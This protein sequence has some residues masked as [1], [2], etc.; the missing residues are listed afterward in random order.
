M[1]RAAY[2]VCLIVLELALVSEVVPPLA[3]ALRWRAAIAQAG[4]G[5]EAALRLTIALLGAAG[6][7][8]ALAAP[9]LA[10]LRHRQR[11]ALRFLGLPRWAVATVI[12]GAAAFAACSLAAPW[13]ADLD[14]RW[15]EAVVEVEQS[16]VLAATALMTGGALAAELLRRSVAPARLLR[17][18]VPSRR[19]RTEAI[20]AAALRP[21]SH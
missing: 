1:L 6:A 13:L 15:A 3:E 18:L 4:D 5:G 16:L 17:E 11:G 20:D 7:G 10:L 2:L 19:G 12:G 8:L 14:H 21:Q 9:L